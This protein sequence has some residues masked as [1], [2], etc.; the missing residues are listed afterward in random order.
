MTIYQVILQAYTVSFL[1]H[2]MMADNI[3]SMYDQ[4][5]DSISFYSVNEVEKITPELVKE[6]MNHLKC[7]DA[8]FEFSSA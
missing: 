1:I 6:A 5:E 7:S 3:S 2:V 8:I 4:L